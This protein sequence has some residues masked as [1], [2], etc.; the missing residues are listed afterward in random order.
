MMS[1]SS[2]V[3]SDNGMLFIKGCIYLLILIYASLID[4][5]TKTIP[6]KV[7]IAIILIGIIGAGIT[8]LIA[9]LII[10]IPFIITTLIKGNGI[11]GGDIKFMAANGFLL[12]M[13]GGFAGSIIGLLLAVVVNTVYYKV[14]KKDKGISFPLAPYLSTGCFFSYLIQF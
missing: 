2:S 6:D 12:G 9:A 5:K 1:L 7:H 3:T 4:I 11:G 8:K 14:K 13:R 10:P